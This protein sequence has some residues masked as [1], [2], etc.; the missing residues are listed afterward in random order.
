MIKYIYMK[1]NEYFVIEAES[2]AQAILAAKG[3]VVIG[4]YSQLAHLFKE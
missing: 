2:L 3:G 1:G 4:E